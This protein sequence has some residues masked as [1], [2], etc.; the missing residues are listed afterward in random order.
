MKWEQIDFRGKS[1]LTPFGVISV[2]KTF[3]VGKNSFVDD[4]TIPENFHEMC[5]NAKIAKLSEITC[6]NHHLI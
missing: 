5:F 6:P 1:I 4:Q 3:F 2:Q